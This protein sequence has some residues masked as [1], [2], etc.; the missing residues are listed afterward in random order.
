M[1]FSLVSMAISMNFTA[2]SSTVASLCDMGR[3]LSPPPLPLS[4][5]AKSAW[6]TTLWCFWGGY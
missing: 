2:C 5:R 4:A 6:S 3:R 1:D